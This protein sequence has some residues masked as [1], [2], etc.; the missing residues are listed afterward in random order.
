MEWIVWTCGW[1]L[2]CVIVEY[3]DAKRRQLTGEP[4]SADLLMGFIKLM[5]WV[6]GMVRTANIGKH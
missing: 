3:I 6:I 1:M 2:T 5:I 4:Q